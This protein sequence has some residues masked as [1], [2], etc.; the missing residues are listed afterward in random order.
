[1]QCIKSSR[2]PFA[3]IAFSWDGQLAFSPG[4]YVWSQSSQI[5]LYICTVIKPP[6]GFC[7][8]ADNSIFVLTLS[9]HDICMET[10]DLKSPIDEYCVLRMIHDNNSSKAHDETC[11]GALHQSSRPLSEETSSEHILD[12]SL[13]SLS[14][15]RR[16]VEGG[17]TSC[18]VNLYCSNL[19]TQSC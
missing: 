15:S 9:Q 12:D 10:S 13:L 3:W 1:M 2:A 19:W 14:Y 17:S 4:S 6:T 18:L 11:R 5:L 7:Q 16:S 8:T